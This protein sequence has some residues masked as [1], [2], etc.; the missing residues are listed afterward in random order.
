LLLSPKETV[1]SHDAI[2]Y[3]G[4]ARYRRSF[5]G[6]FG[7]AEAFLFLRE[8]TLRRLWREERGYWKVQRPEKR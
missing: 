3:N 4:I 1:A 5:G 7:A 6:S 2:L 8:K